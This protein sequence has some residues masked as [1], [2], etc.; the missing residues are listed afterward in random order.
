MEKSGSIRRALKTT[1]FMAAMIGSLLSLLV[2]TAPLLLVLTDML[3]PSALLYTFTP[4]SSVR[5]VAILLRNYDFRSSLVDIPLISIARSVVITC[6]YSLC[7]G[8][9]LSYG[10]YVGVTVLCSLVSVMVVALKAWA[11]GTAVVVDGGRFVYYHNLQQQNESHH[12]G[13]WQVMGMQVM[14][15]C[16]LVLALG[17]IAAA[18]RTRRKER[19]KL[20]LYRIDPEAVFVYKNG[21]LPGGYHNTK[22]SH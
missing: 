12:H 22:T 21:M 11:F 5:S 14:M 20:L 15:M 6:V 10:P 18:Y 7:D 2:F 16:S 3:L 17:H 13:L 1:I 4:F 8:R 9:G 19:K